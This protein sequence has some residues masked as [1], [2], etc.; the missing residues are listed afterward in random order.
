MVAGLKDRERRATEVGVSHDVHGA[1]EW[2]QGTPVDHD[3]R[4][5]HGTHIR[6]LDRVIVDSIERL[7]FRRHSGLVIVT[8]KDWRSQQLLCAQMPLDQGTVHL[9]AI[10]ARVDSALHE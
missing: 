6:D 4:I 8:V 3:S 2:A 7:A 10:L 5:K 9:F 1:V